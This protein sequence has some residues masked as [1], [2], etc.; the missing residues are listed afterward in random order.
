MGFILLVLSDFLKL[1]IDEVC[2]PKLMGYNVF[3]HLF[4]CLLLCVKSAL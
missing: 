1:N 3:V 4:V 2:H